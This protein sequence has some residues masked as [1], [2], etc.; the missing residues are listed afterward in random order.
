MRL[1]IASVFLL[2]V[3]QDSGDQDF[4]GDV[5]TD[6]DDVVALFFHWDSGC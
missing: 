2:A 5:D 6:S 4:D 3:A 1:A